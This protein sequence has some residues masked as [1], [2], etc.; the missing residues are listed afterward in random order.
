MG[1]VQ[2]M[3]GY[4]ELAD[5]A[6]RSMGGEASEVERDLGETEG[7]PQQVPCSLFDSVGC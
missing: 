6:M 1:E 7:P 2:R 5:L 4:A 3:L